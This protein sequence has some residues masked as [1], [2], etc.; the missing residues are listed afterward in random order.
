VDLLFV[1]DAA[2]IYPFGLEQAVARAAAG[3][4]ASSTARAGRGHFDG[5]AT[6]RLPVLNS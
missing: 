4:S 5:V 3:L 2:E 6:V 1:P